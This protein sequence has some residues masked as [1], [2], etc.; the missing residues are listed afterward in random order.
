MRTHT[1]TLK[2]SRGRKLLLSIAAIG[3]AASIAGFGTF[4]TF[5]SS[6]SASHTIAS[7]TLS[8]TAPFSRLGTGAS[9]IAAGDTMQRA[10]DLSYSG[11][12]NFGSAT[13]TTTAPTSSGL[14]T[15]AV[16]GLQIAIDKCSQAWTESGPPYTYTCGGSTSTVLSSRALIGSNI[17]LSNLTLTAGATDHL[18]VTVTLASSAGNTL[19]NLSSTIN[20]AFTGV[21]RAATDQ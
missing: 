15:D 14:D 9:A 8:L 2:G 7:G 6:T 13:L 18:R 17:A 10:I 4:A 12:I 11:S 5:T 20:Y 3:A 21:Q 16:N 19:Q 1:R